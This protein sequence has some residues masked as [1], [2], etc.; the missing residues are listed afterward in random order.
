M[1]L[2]DVCSPCSVLKFSPMFRVK[3]YYLGMALEFLSLFVLLSMLLFRN[4]FRIVLSSSASG[5]ILNFSIDFG[6]FRIGTF[7]F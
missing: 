5:S 1:G 6:L 3:S 7:L 4:E 2:L